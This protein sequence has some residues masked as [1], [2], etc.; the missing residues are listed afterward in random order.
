MSGK[1]Y[2]SSISSKSEEEFV[3]WPHMLEPERSRVEVENLVEGL[4]FK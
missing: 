1:G 3:L 2:D 4:A